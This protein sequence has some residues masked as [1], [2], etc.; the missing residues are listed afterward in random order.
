MHRTH[1]AALAC[2]LLV[3]V[4][5]CSGSGTEPTA[6][7]TPAEVPETTAA[8]RLA[9][10][11]TTTATPTPTAR[12]PG[13]AVT[14]RTALPNASVGGVAFPPGSDGRGLVNRQTLLNA[15]ERAAATTGYVL[16]VNETVRVLRDDGNR[17]VEDT[18]SVYRVSRT[19]GI[20]ARIRRSASDG[21]NT[22]L[23]VYANATGVFTRRGA[24]GNATYRRNEPINLEAARGDIAIE[25]LDRHLDAGDWRPTGPTTVEGRAAVAFAFEPGL[26]DVER[27]RG[28]LVATE[29][30]VVR[31]LTFRTVAETGEE[32]RVE[33]VTY[34]FDPR[35]DLAVAPPDW[36][37][38]AAT[39]TGRS[40]TTASRT[41]GERTTEPED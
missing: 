19:G 40:T 16:V 5:G 21:V 39:G 7:I 15:H 31:L 14:R 27:A 22:T 8:S 1:V 10:A 30:G 25:R 12:D 38:E 33:S 29:R 23:D 9:P 26:D 20:A 36:L 2:V 24:D 41:P 35:P 3:A 4:T 32:R 37:A 17:I 11:P 28:T 34:R 6:T 18:R 13:P